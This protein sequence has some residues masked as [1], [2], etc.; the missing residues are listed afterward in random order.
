MYRIIIYRNKKNGRYSSKIQLR[1]DVTF[2]PYTFIDLLKGSNSWLINILAEQG[3]IQQRRPEPIPAFPAPVLGICVFGH[4]Y[5]TFVGFKNRDER[6]Y[7]SACAR[8]QADLNLHSFYEINLE[9]YLFLRI[10]GLNV[11][12]D[13]RKPNTGPIKRLLC[14]NSQKVNILLWS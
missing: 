6:R 12:S 2:F 5:M 7:R 1:I 13:N 11:P 9:R 14:L 3:K 4:K 8:A 10:P